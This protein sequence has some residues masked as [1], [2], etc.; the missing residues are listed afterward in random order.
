M[1]IEIKW[2][3]LKSELIKQSWDVRT[4]S[5]DADRA[6]KELIKS[7]KEYLNSNNHLQELLAKCNT[8]KKSIKE[9]MV[10]LK[11][12]SPPRDLV[13][14]LK[15]E[16]ANAKN[17]QI[18]VK[19]RFAILQKQLR[20]IPN[21]IDP[22]DNVHV[23]DERVVSSVKHVFDYSP[24]ID[25]IDSNN[26]EYF[27]MNEFMK[28]RIG[29]VSRELKSK[30]P[31]QERSLD[32]LS[33]YKKSWL[34]ESTQLPV[35]THQLC[36]DLSKVDICVICRGEAQWSR[37][38]F[39]KLTICACEYYCRIINSGSSKFEPTF[40]N[41]IEIIRLKPFELSSE[42]SITNKIL[43]GGNCAA[44]I[45]CTTDFESRDYEIRCGSKKNLQSWKKYVHVVRATWYLLDLK[46]LYGNESF[47]CVDFTKLNRLSFVPQ[48]PC[49][50]LNGV[51]HLFRIPNVYPIKIENLDDVV[52]LDIWLNENS[53]IQGSF[54]SSPD[55]DAQN[56]LNKFLQASMTSLPPVQFPHIMRWLNTIS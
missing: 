5:K 29:S 27:M 11:K 56:E 40:M 52:N 34:D 54:L 48:Q 30:T 44:E 22:S 1:G 35:V 19:N 16:E 21:I 46:N 39:R 36:A 15:A 55:T 12:G 51:E 31:K 14:E 10:K 37:N 41:D 7:H 23:S 13:I 53:F 2:L 25:N 28:A 20:S 6:I 33:L 4:G 47:C 18:T 42:S 45:T 50:I 8:I 26:L 24:S 17:F 3:Y 38:V 49:E 43:I 9:H 32:L